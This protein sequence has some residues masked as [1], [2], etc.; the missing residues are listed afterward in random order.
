MILFFILGSITVCGLFSFLECILPN[1]EFS[2]ETWN[3]LETMSG[4]IIIL[5]MVFSVLGICFL[6]AS[7]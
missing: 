2:K 3:L 7:Q 6:S 1:I 5:L 4:I